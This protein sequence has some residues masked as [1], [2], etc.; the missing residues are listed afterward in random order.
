MMLTLP[1]M[2]TYLRTYECVAV[3]VLFSTVTLSSDTS[4]PPHF[5]Q[6]HHLQLDLSWSFN[7]FFWCPFPQLPLQYCWRACCMGY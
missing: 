1:H 5:T 4:P 2:H 7:H 6:T 3:T